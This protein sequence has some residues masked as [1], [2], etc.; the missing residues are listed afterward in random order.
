MNSYNADPAVT[1]EY[2]ILTTS[3]GPLWI[4]AENDQLIGSWFDQQRYFPDTQGWRKAQTALLMQAAEQLTDYFQGQRQSFELPLAPRGTPFQK[5][6]WHQLQTLPYGSTTEYG[7]LALA[8]GRPTATRAIAAAIGRNPLSILIPCH[9]VV[10]KNGQLTGY[11]G[12]L[13]RK[14]SLLKLEASH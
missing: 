10:G 8:M 12:G 6:V 11:A 7:K 1:I 5:T 13:A 9:R 3:L 4:A 2:M 14:A